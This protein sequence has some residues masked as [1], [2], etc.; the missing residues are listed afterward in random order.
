MVTA[1]AATWKCRQL[2]V[3]GVA[4]TASAPAALTAVASMAPSL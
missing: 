2:A 3:R 4:G 1:A